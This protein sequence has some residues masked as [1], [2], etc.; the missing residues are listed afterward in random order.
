MKTDL[1]P[2]LDDVME[3]RQLV[4]EENRLRRKEKR[5]A[6]KDQTRELSKRVV[7]TIR[8]YRKRNLPAGGGVVGGERKMGAMYNDC[9]DTHRRLKFGGWLDPAD[10]FKHVI[11]M[12]AVL[13]Q[14]ST[15]ARA[16]DEERVVVGLVYWTDQNNKRRLEAAHLAI[17]IYP[18]ARR[19]ERQK[20]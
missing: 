5:N 20:T 1:P 12:I 7:K 3:K 18:R 11:G 14:D 15:I 8:Y 19:H 10:Q 16:I 17:R 13:R 4:S 2:P 9:F 6:V